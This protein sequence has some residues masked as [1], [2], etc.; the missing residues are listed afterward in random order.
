MLSRLFPT[1]RE[2][3]AD[4]E[5]CFLQGVGARMANSTVGDLWLPTLTLLFQTIT[6]AFG[7]YKVINGPSVVTTLTISLVWI[8]YGM[9][10]NILLMYYVWIGHGHS[11]QIT[12]KVMYLIR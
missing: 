8:L 1:P 10:P 2:G 5:C 3:L 7:V 9:I 4:W 12:C 11:L 6:F